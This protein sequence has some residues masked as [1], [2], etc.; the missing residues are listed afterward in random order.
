MRVEIVSE[1]DPGDPILEIPW[2][3]PDRPRLK[4]VDL[5]KFPE[6]IASLTECRNYPPLAQLLRRF[7]LPRSTFRTV[8]CD[9][10][11]TTQLE[12]DEKLDFQLPLKVGSYVDFVFDRSYLHSRL[13][14]HLR[15]GKMLEKLLADCRLQAQVEIVVRRCLFHKNGKWGYSLTLFVHA[16]GATRSEAKREWGRALDGL[17]DALRRAAPAIAKK[18][19][20]GLDRR[21]RG[22]I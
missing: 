11:I 1:L 12:E 2:A 9:V 19:P 3:S 13:E 4:Y 17:G 6:K 14:P 8:K 21:T 22:A 20:K 16:Y 7:N 10:W 5:R 15:L 18:R